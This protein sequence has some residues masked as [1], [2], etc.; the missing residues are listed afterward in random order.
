[1]FNLCFFKLK[2]CNLE[3]GLATI[4]DEKNEWLEETV[5]YG[6]RMW[7]CIFLSIG[8]VLSFSKIIKYFET[9]KKFGNLNMVDIC[10]VFCSHF[11]MLLL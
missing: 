8:A 10:V 9:I 6:M 4:F 1:M 3:P 2:G 7:H 11:I 5:W